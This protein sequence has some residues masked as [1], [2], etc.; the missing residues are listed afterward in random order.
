M[1]LIDKVGGVS[2]GIIV[3]LLLMIILVISITDWNIKGYIFSPKLY[4]LRIISIFRWIIPRFVCVYIT[5]KIMESLGIFPRCDSWADR[6]CENFGILKEQ[7]IW[8]TNVFVSLL[9]VNFLL[10]IESTIWCRE[11]LLVAENSRKK[12]KEGD[13]LHEVIEASNQLRHESEFG[14]K[15]MPA[16]SRTVGVI[17]EW[18]S[19]KSTF[20]R[21]LEAKLN[22]ILFDKHFFS[23]NIRNWIL[24]LSCVFLIYY[25]VQFFEFK[26][27]NV[28]WTIF[29]KILVCIISCYLLKIS[30]RFR[31]DLSLKNYENIFNI[32]LVPIFFDSWQW[33]S[34]AAP[35]ISLL[36]CIYNHPL[37]T[38]IAWFRRPFVL[39]WARI[40]RRAS[41]SI[42]GFSV[43]SMDGGEKENSIPGIHPY[44]LALLAREYESLLS[45][46]KVNNIF[47]VILIDEVDRCE[48]FYTQSI[49]SLLPRYLNKDNCFVYVSLVQ[50]QIEGR[51]FTPLTAETQ[52]LTSNKDVEEDCPVK[53]YH[54][55]LWDTLSIAKKSYRGEKDGIF[56]FHALSKFFE[57]Y[58]FMSPLSFH[59][60]H[61]GLL[62]LLKQ[63][64]AEC[65]NCP[66]KK[67]NLNFEMMKNAESVSIH[68]ESILRLCEAQTG[69]A[70][71][72]RAINLALR[73][74]FHNLKFH[75]RKETMEWNSS[76][77]YFFNGKSNIDNNE[78]FWII[79]RVALGL[80]W[81]GIVEP[82][83]FR[84]LS[85]REVSE[86][87][88]GIL[89]LTGKK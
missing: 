13:W 69:L 36:E 24:F 1:D 47:L 60:M 87:F 34:T 28:H 37:I 23:S 54:S 48:R 25:L 52:K 46:L 38:R 65:F 11:Y 84:H 18:G 80:Y 21:Q 66:L 74:V 7:E 75:F 14:T 61:G 19:G 89:K 73:T 51:L 45:W 71:N 78:I 42:K 35:E 22:E 41:F 5:I 82:S 15:K 30:N 88:D 3:L 56:R 9:V 31:L 77:C 76:S 39:W 55:D 17:G 53:R 49:L 29:L 67:C 58:I 86:A 33:Q 83:Y 50:S 27:Y 2:C 10:I 59:D 26:S 40:I 16:T 32:R 81:Y 57:S 6:I 12:K 64:C 4:Y 20:L 43:N 44:S 63:I 8:K 85:G 68:I 72:P 79:V 70:G 62:N